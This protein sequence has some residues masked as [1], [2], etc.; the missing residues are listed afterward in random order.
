VKS[1]KHSDFSS[2]YIW[3]NFSSKLCYHFVQLELTHRNSLLMIVFH[4]AIRSE[5]ILEFLE[6][7][8]DYILS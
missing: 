6:F 3:S 1:G 8:E 2:L 7:P 4:D 5:T